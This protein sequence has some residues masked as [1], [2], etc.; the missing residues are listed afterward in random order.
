[1]KTLIILFFSEKSRIISLRRGVTFLGFRIFYKHR[2]LKKSNAKR[3]WKRLERFKRK[4]DKGEMSRKEVV[5]SL[6][7]WLA[8]AEFANTYKFRKRVVA[9][10]NELFHPSDNQENY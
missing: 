7:G 9:E 3:I 4:Y 2:L 10:F 6:E 1:M 5:Q 8:Y